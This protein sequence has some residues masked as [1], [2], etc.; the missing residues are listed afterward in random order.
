MKIF[1]V[2]ENFKKNFKAAGWFY[3]G[4]LLIAFGFFKMADP[5]TYDVELRKERAWQKHQELV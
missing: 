5:A 4:I 2:A 1:N 3:I